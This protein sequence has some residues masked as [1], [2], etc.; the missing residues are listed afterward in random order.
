MN[1]PRVAFKR[2][3]QINESENGL[4]K[5]LIRQFKLRLLGMNILNFIFI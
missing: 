5:K 2:G 4:R 1:D 3:K